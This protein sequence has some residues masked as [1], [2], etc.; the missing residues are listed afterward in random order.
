MM[1]RFIDRARAP[2][3]APDFRSAVAVADQSL[4][5]ADDPAIGQRRVAAH[6]GGLVVVGLLND[7]RID[8]VALR[9]DVRGIWIGQVDWEHPILGRL[10]AAL[11]RRLRRR[12][13]HQLLNAH[14]GGRGAE[15]RASFGWGVDGLRLDYDAP[16][17][18]TILALAEMMAPH[19]PWRV[20][21]GGLNFIGEFIQ[22]PVIDHAIERL[23]EL[24]LVAHDIDGAQATRQVAD[25]MRSLS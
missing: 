14:L 7:I 16:N 6:V 22:D 9:R 13:H 17:T 24:I 12:A 20:I 3:T 1:E 25:A 4:P 15:M 19:G 8:R 21:R 5:G 10:P 2:S 18:E 11:P 23:A